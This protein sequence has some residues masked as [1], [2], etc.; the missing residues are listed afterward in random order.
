[1]KTKS[2]IILFAV[3]CACMLTSCSHNASL[4]GIGSAFRM[5]SGE[6]SIWYGDGMFLNSVSRENV[7]FKSELDSTMG[8]AFDPTNGTYKGI[9]S[10]SLEVGPQLGGYARELGEKNPDALRA[11]YEALAKYYEYREKQEALPV[12]QKSAI[13]DEK[14]KSATSEVSDIIRKAVDAAK[15]IAKKYTNSEEGQKEENKFV[16]EDGNCSYTNLHTNGDIEYQLSIAMKLLTYNGYARSF[17]STGEYYQTTLEHFITQLVKHQG[18]GDKTTP[19][20]VKYVTVK[21]G[22]I[23]DLMYIMYEDGKVFDVDCPSCVSW[24]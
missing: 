12:Q 24:E 6:A 20:R 23:I 14:S 22:D 10:I 2:I 5:G 8:V 9:K 17:E 15:A 11:Y 7:R 3:A 1:M 16:C 4:L 19:L 13:S 18:K 21:D